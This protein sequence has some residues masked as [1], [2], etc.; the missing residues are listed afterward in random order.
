MCLRLT[1]LLDTTQPG[2]NNRFMNLKN[3]FPP[4]I[5]KD[6]RALILGSMP[7][8]ESLR[9]NEYYGNP[10]NAFWRIMAALFNFDPELS[11]YE[12]IKRLKENHIALWDVL[13][14]CE[15]QGSLDT[16][17]K[18]GTIIIFSNIHEVLIFL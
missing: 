9:R 5:C 14:R 16:E 2:R 1:H 15:R 7:G 3:G 12:K 8:E 18:N 11:Y 10:R 6:A 4:I 13:K 17:I